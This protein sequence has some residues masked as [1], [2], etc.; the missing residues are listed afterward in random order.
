MMSAERFVDGYKYTRQDAAKL[1]MV[2]AGEVK[3][4]NL[5]IFAG[6]SVVPGSVFMH[7]FTIKRDKPL[8]LGALLHSLTLWQAEGGTIGGQSARGHGRLA[9]MVF[10]IDPGD[11]DEAVAEYEEFALSMKDSVIAWIESSFTEKAKKPTKK[12]AKEL[13]TTEL[14]SDSDA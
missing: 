9:T 13:A 14:A 12:G 11:A 1:G 6:Q 5:M 8:L 10:G 7:G 4:S 2:D 3:D